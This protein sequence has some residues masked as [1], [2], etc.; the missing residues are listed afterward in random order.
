MTRLSDEEREMLRNLSSHSGSEPQL[1]LDQ[2]F[3]APTPEARERY[4]DFASQAAVFY[5]GDRPIGL[6]GNQWKL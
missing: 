2:R 4:I 6:R 3:V 1:P 5:K